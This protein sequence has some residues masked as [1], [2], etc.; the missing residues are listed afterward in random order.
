MPGDWGRGANFQAIE[1][2]QIE[3]NEGMTMAGAVGGLGVGG[4]SIICPEMTSARR[5]SQQERMQECPHDRLW[6]VCGPWVPLHCGQRRGVGVGG[7][8]GT[9]ETVPRASF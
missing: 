8:A 4:R 6:L 5:E 7:V 9:V 1:K 2:V 3:G